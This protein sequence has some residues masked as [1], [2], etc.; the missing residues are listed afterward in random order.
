MKGHIAT[1]M[2]TRLRFEIENCPRHELEKDYENS[3]ET[4]PI[5][6]HEMEKEVTL[7]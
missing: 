6:Q 1:R 4:M 3:K 5:G 2:Q 7:P